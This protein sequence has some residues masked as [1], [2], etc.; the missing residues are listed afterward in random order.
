MD[1]EKD[2]SVKK[3]MTPKE[4]KKLAAIIAGIVIIALLC[5]GIMYSRK[6]SDSYK[7]L[8]YDKYIKLGE[9]KGLTY[10]EKDAVIKQEDIDAEIENRLALE[11]ETTTIKEGK[12]ED[13]DT[14]NIDYTGKIDGKEFAG[15]SSTGYELTIGSKTFIDGFE[16]GLVGKKVGDTVEV[17]V[18]FPEDYQDEAMAGK[19]AVF[20]VKINSKIKSKKPEYNEEFIKAHSDYDNK[21][22]YEASI[23]KELEEELKKNNTAETKQELWEQVMSGSKVKKY[24][25]KQYKAEKAA[26]Q[27]YYKNVAEQYGM[28]YSEFQKQFNVTDDQLKETAKDS[29]K[30]KLCIYAIAKKEGLKVTDKE[31]REAID[32]LLKDAGFT[33]SSFKKQYGESIQEY[34]KEQDYRTS[35]LLEKVEDFILENGKV[36]K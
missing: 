12:V 15:G 8:D 11:E 21:K 1:K 33:E 14:V 10:Q 25:K 36:S 35:L 17:K 5:G 34:A 16:D 18:T 9:Y 32:K 29:V 24:P 30:S 20:S 31:Y 28:E 23:K 26:V 27:A 7:Y 3:K 13:G 6:S 22:D 4:K 2:K 19:D